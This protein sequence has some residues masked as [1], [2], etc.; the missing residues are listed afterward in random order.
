MTLTQLTDLWR[1]SIRLTGGRFAIFAG[2][3]THEERMAR[4]RKMILDSNSSDKPLGKR[5]GEVWSYSRAFRHIFGEP[6]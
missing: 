4:T 1:L 3:T 5:H 2:I 6:L